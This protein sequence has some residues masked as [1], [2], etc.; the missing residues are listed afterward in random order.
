VNL[1]IISCLL[2]PQ[3]IT[4]PAT[5]LMLNTLKPFNL[6]LNFFEKLIHVHTCM[7]KYCIYISIPFS[8]FF[9]PL[10]SLPILS[11]IYDV[12]YSNY[13]YTHTHTHTHTLTRCWIYLALCT[14]THQSVKKWTLHLPSGTEQIFSLHRTCNL[15]Y[16]ILTSSQELL[17][18]R[19]FWRS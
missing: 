4:F 10:C 12:F 5:S 8:V 19:K 17:K 1:K 16:C 18:I 13:Y 3:A 7:Y 11:Q 9:N 6:F 14:H 2:T 15:S